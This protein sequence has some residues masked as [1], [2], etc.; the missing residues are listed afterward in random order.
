MDYDYL[1][2]KFIHD[3]KYIRFGKVKFHKELINSKLNKPIG[4]GEFE[5]NREEKTL[6]LFGVSHD[7]GKYNINMIKHII[8]NLDNH[9]ITGFRNIKDY[10][11]KYE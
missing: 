6:R 3:E 8:E 11:I 5:F 1:K 9:H 4:G 7:F 10:N 2:L